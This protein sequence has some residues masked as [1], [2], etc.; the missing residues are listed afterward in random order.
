MRDAFICD[1]VRTV[2]RY[3]GR[4]PLYARTIW[5]PYR[6][7]PCWSAIRSSTPGGLMM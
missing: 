1:G 4:Y 7:V 6:C 2:G 5:A 3:G